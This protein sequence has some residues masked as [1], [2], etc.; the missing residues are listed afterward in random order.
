MPNVSNNNKIHKQNIN[1]NRKKYFAN[2]SRKSNLLGEKDY[3]WFTLSFFFLLV[4]FSDAG[5]FFCFWNP[6]FLLSPP[7][8][9]FLQEVDL[10][11]DLFHLK[12]LLVDNMVVTWQILKWEVH[13]KL[14][15]LAVVL[16]LTWQNEQRQVL[17]SRK[18]T[19]LAFKKLK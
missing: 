17:G 5:F 7:P 18:T 10:G 2:A 8:L 19:V 16:P 11:R 3:F 14:A 6:S 4:D 12:S 9:F 13:W 1:Q 15:T